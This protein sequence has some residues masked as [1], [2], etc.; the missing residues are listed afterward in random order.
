MAGLF[1]IFPEMGFLVLLLV[2]FGVL[3]CSSTI[4]AMSDF[5]SFL[6]IYVDELLSLLFDWI[7]I[8][9]ISDVLILTS[10]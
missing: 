10:Y 6:C 8:I 3:N 9:K 2:V 5:F 7:L 1:K 4:K